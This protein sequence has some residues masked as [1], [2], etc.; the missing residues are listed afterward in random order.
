MQWVDRLREATGW[1]QQRDDDT[2]A[3]TESELGPSLPDDYKELCVRFGPGSFS[4]FV[5]LL[6]G[7]Y[8]PLYDLRSDWSDPPRS[9]P[10]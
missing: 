7:G 10:R 8:D 2:W 5:S 3:L 6:R 4:G 9:R 1:V